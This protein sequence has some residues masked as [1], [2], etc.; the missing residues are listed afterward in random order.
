VLE[1][2]VLPH[3]FG[4]LKDAR[5]VALTCKTWAVAMK[6]FC[7]WQWFLELRQRQAREVLLD[8]VA[9][10]AYN[11]AETIRMLA[12][13][14]SL[15]ELVQSFSCMLCTGFSSKLLHNG[16]GRNVK[17]SWQGGAFEV[18]GKTLRRGR[19]EAGKFCAG[20]SFSATRVKEICG[21]NTLAFFLADSSHL[22][23]RHYA[24]KVM[25]LLEM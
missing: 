20:L 8:V 24:V 7:C 14:L 22:I 25:I 16:D 15:V 11:D 17:R 6:K 4:T 10:G 5:N 18:T 2:C 3:S 23:W 19:F 12:S 13:K 21:D 1:M 9:L